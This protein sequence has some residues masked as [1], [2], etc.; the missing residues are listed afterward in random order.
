MGR[1]YCKHRQME[2][3]RVYIK[4]V[5]VSNELT[6]NTN[7]HVLKRQKKDWNLQNSTVI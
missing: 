5:G 3:Y 4:C 1:L 6:V 7:G 2:R